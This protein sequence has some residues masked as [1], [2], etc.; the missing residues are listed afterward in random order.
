CR[1]HVPQVDVAG[2]TEEEEEDAG[3]APPPGEPGRVSAGSCG[4]GTQSGQLRGGEAEE[5]QAADAEQLPPGGAVA[6]AHRMIHRGHGFPP[7]AR[8]P[9]DYSRVYSRRRPRV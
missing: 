7:R 8:E 1:L 9:G 3:V 4:K 6:Q 2:P 5:A